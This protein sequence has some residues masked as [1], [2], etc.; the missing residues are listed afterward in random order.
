MQSQ[1]DDASYLLLVNKLT[2]ITKL[3]DFLFYS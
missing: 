3:Y 1:W 2:N